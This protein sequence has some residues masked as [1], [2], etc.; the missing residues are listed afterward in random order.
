MTKI[1]FNPSKNNDEDNI[2]SIKNNDEDNI[3]SH[4]RWQLNFTVHTRYK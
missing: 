3:E 2:E 4:P 1:I